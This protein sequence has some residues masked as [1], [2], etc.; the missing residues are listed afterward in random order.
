MS[1]TSNE[2]GHNG[3]YVVAL[4]CCAGSIAAAEVEKLV[5]IETA[6]V[7]WEGYPDSPRSKARNITKEV[8][9]KGKRKSDHKSI[10]QDLRSQANSGGHKQ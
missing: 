3:W 4:T 1:Q 2:E 7:T 10:S 9:S 6:L 5:V 8:S